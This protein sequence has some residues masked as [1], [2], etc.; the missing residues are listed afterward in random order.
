MLVK[1]AKWVLLLVIWSIVCLLRGYIMGAKTNNIEEC[2][3]YVDL[4]VACL[5]NGNFYFPDT[6]EAFRCDTQ[7]LGKL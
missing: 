5:N 7:Y 3:P 1:R 4:M 6:H 2:G